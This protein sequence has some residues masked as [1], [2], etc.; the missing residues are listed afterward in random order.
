MFWAWF[1][2]YDTIIQSL[3]ILKMAELVYSMVLIFSDLLPL[4]SVTINLMSA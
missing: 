1:S 4:E 2:S 3:L